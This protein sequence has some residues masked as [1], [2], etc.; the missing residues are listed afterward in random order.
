MAFIQKTTVGLN[1]VNSTAAAPSLTG[2]VAGNTL[3]WITS[4]YQTLDKVPTDSAGQTWVKAAFETVLAHASDVGVYYLLNANAGTHTLSWLVG[5]SPN[6]GYLWGTLAECPKSS[7]L[8][9]AG[10]GTAITT[11]NPTTIATTVTTSAASTFAVAGMAIG[12]NAGNSNC[13]ITTP[14][15]WT[16]LSVE[17]DSASTQAAE[18]SYKEQTSAGLQTATWNFAADPTS[19]TAGAVAVSFVNTAGGGSTAALTAVA[20]TTGLGATLGAVTSKAAS[21][22]TATGTPGTAAANV[23]IALTGVT[24]VTSTGTV[25]SG[26]PILAPVTTTLTVGTAKAGFTLALTAVQ[27]TSAVSSVTAGLAAPLTAVSSASATGAVGKGADKPLTGATATGAPGTMGLSMGQALSG[28]SST[29]TVNAAGAAVTVALS[30]V[31]STTSVGT[32]R[33]PGLLLAPVST[34]GTPGTVVPGVAHALSGVSSTSTPGSA[35]ATPTS[36]ISGVQATGSAGT[37]HFG[38]V[39]VG[40]SGVSS[41]GSA[42]TLAPPAAP[43]YRNAELFMAIQSGVSG[44][45]LN[46]LRTVVPNK[47]GAIMLGAGGTWTVPSGAT[48]VFLSATAGGGSPFGLAGQ[49]L[50]HQWL[51]VKPGDVL[52]VTFDSLG[53]ITVMDG[54]V[55]LLYLYAG[56]PYKK[57]AWQSTF[58]QSSGIAGFGSGVD[59]GTPFPPI[60]V[61]YWN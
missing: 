13:A 8:D 56:P 22:N 47:R 7:G 17:N 48:N 59:A 11:G 58:G 45:Y 61:F 18:H 27:A 2:V 21:G 25:S 39:V 51:A 52:T 60:L 26:P 10:G 38:N 14:T 6:D 44:F 20:S 54:A 41:H 9:V 49:Q 40:L 23:S 36:P 3:V 50:F 5:D 46:N 35:T 1:G 31:S 37:V 34:A 24:S 19:A 53:N 12:S 57:R 33:G 15:G 28:V 43:D 42:G 30:G 16:Q 4:S 55:Q 29:T 32:V